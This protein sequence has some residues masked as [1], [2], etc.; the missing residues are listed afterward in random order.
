MALKLKVR[1]QFPANVIATSPIILTKNGLTYTFTFDSSALVINADAIVLGSQTGTGPLV[2]ANDPTFGNITIADNKAITVGSSSPAP[3]TYNR[4]ELNGPAGGS[5]S[6]AIIYAKYGG[7]TGWAIGNMSAVDGGAFSLTTVF[8]SFNGLRFEVNG[9]SAGFMTLDSSGNL[10]TTN[11][12]V[13]MLRVKA[14]AVDFNSA[15]TD[16]PINI[17]LPAGFTKYLLYTVAINNASQTLTTATA[18]VFSAAAAGGT[19]VVTGG[20]AITVNTAAANTA[21]NNQYMTFTAAGVSMLNFA[22]LY[23]RVANAQGAP[24]TADVEVFYLPVA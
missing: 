24:A 12:G 18:G 15:N 2:H 6:G 22:T 21:G 9:V 5:N 1:T 13:G 23:F 3:G 8:R 16:T 19:A 11:A 17:V 10:A 7:A 4:I 20:S 14:S